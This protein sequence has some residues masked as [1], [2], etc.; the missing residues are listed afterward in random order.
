MSDGCCDCSTAF[1]GRS[2]TYRR[3]LGVVIA[4]NA[5][6]FVV[7]LAAGYLARSQALQADAL[8][9]LG[10]ALTYGLTLLVIGRPLTWRARAALVKGLSIG[11]LA[12]WV[13][14]S[15]LWRA[16]QGG[17][18]ELL[19]MGVIG[20]L[21]LCVNIS[22][23]TLLYR[24]REGDANVRSA[25]LCSRN[26]AM[27][28]SRSLLRRSESGL[29]AGLGR[30]SPSPWRCRRCSC[31]PRSAS[32]GRRGV[33]CDKPATLR[34]RCCKAG[35][36]STARKALDSQAVRAGQATCQTGAIVSPVLLLAWLGSGQP[37]SS[38]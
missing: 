4:L 24:F 11:A 23:A 29:P 1:D 19:T 36:C 10:D 15:T 34:R 5:A 38:A 7:E 33:N 18:P 20:L 21:A 12:L 32:S 8:D 26:D 31:I 6:M 2:V 14:G 27:A 28:T 25:W 30:T 16:V 13:A 3:V 37:L 35:L 9:F 22:A 17:A